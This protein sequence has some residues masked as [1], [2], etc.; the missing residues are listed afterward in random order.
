MP[1]VSGSRLDA[2][3]TA[4]K[5]SIDAYQMLCSIA[6]A[7]FRSSSVMFP[8]SDLNAFALSQN[9]DGAISIYL[10]AAGNLTPE[11]IGDMLH[12]CVTN[13]N[14]IDY[15][16]NR[17]ESLTRYLLLMAGDLLPF[18]VARDLRGQFREIWA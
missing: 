12:Q 10:D 2:T 9:H 6:S 7:A 4:F 18:E 17:I 16:R 3:F 15:F 1:D 13:N 5:S 11:S 14:R 8:S